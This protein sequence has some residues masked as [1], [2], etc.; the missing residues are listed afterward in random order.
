MGCLLIKAHL[1][2]L[3]DIS[4]SPEDTNHTPSR[5]LWNL[6]QLDTEGTENHWTNKTQPRDKGWYRVLDCGRE[7]IY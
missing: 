5:E 3:P 6:H 7:R 2:L 4:K 1:K